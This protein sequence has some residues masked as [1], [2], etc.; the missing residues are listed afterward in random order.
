MKRREFGKRFSALVAGVAVTN[1]VTLIQE[2]GEDA[3]VLPPWLVVMCEEADYSPWSFQRLEARRPTPKEKQKKIMKR[4]T[5]V[6]IVYL[7]KGEEK[8][9]VAS[10]FERLDTLTPQIAGA[11]IDEMV[12]L[13]QPRPLL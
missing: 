7:V 2:M 1:P 8:L 12:Y 4:A 6:L 10:T 9:W 5:V 3:I 13:A 11:Y